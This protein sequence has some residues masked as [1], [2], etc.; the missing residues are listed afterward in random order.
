MQNLPFHPSYI[1]TLPEDT[2]NT[3]KDVLM[4]LEGAHC[5]DGFCFYTRIKPWRFCTATD[6]TL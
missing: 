6:L 4:A 5:I 3:H 2:F 1:P